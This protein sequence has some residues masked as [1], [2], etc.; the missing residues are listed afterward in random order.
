MAT[1]TTNQHAHHQ[2]THHVMGLGSIDFFCCGHCS[3]VWGMPA[4]FVEARRHDHASF[5]CPNGHV[6]SYSGDNAEEKLRKQLAEATRQRELARDRAASERAARDQAEASLRATK[7][8]VTR[9]K[10]RAA[11]GVCPAGCKRHFTDLERHMASKHPEYAGEK[12]P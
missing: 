9:L 10:N 1:R 11:A 8:H 12:K 2:G 4:P 6:W 3:I 7:G 5:R